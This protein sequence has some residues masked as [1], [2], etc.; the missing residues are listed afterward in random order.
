MN[1]FE[2]FKD[3]NACSSTAD[4]LRSTFMHEK[5]K[6]Y[7]DNVKGIP[8]TRYHDIA[9]K[10][11]GIQPGIWS[12]LSKANVGKTTLLMSMAVD[13]LE[14]ACKKGNKPVK[15]VVYTFDD[16]DDDVR[17]M[18]VAAI[19]GVNKD[20]VDR[21]RL[22]P[23]DDAKVEDAYNFLITLSE[24]GLFCLR[25]FRDIQDV[26][27]LLDDIKMQDTQMKAMMPEAKL[28][29]FMD[30]QSNLSCKGRDIREMNINKANLAMQI[31]ADLKFPFLVSL[32]VPKLNNRWRPIKEDSAESVKYAYNSKVSI[33]MSPIDDRT[34]EE[35]GYTVIM[36]KID[37]NKFSGFKGSVFGY[38][39]GGKARF[40][41]ANDDEK[42][43]IWN[44]VQE[45]N[46]RFYGGKR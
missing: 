23:A 24:A 7:K 9:N 25:S 6:V 4:Y 26:D 15:V 32:E 30:G 31:A 45:F 11:G 12:I 38:L 29:V 1:E 3:G 19:A 42:T 14:T 2:V 28:A 33:C 46:K 44:R 21:K 41:M 5:N 34:E 43:G 20:I 39:E 27:A 18:L 35:P 37:K 40:R 36:M 13:M 16:S 17:W 22:S 10:T 8:L